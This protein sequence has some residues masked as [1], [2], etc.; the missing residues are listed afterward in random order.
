LVVKQEAPELTAMDLFPVRRD[1]LTTIFA[2]VLTYLIITVQ[3]QID[4]PSPQG[5]LSPPSSQTPS[6]T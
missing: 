1:T 5:Y 6:S 4:E 2:T 3:F